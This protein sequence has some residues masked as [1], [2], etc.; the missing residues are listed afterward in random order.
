MGTA[1]AGRVELW[2][3]DLV[4]TVEYGLVEAP[5][6][7]GLQPN[8]DCRITS[9]L[10][11]TSLLAVTETCPDGS[12]W[13]RLQ[14][15]TPEES[16]SPEVERDIPLDDPAARLV[17]VGES[18]ATVHFP[19]E[20]P[21][22]VSYDRQGRETERQPTAPAPL[23]ADSPAPFAAATADLP[24]HMSWF[25]GHRLHL[26]TP[27]DLRVDHVFEGAVGTGVAVADRLLFPVAEGVAVA[28]WV[29]GTV[30][31]TIPVDRGGYTGMIALDVVGDTVVEK[32]E[33]QIVGLAAG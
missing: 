6:E 18:A 3:S 31:R 32:R 9:A 13:L 21:Q 7:A 25:D 12:S 10:T 20:Q 14:K 27:T 23:V 15:A 8:P 29:T 11:R 5:Q 4:R 24:H 33:G 16:R 26:L 30:E 22:L 19:G 28:D 2:R 1:G 17:A